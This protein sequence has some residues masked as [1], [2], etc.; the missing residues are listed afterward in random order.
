M[1][2]D[3]RGFSYRIKWMS[4]I[5][6]HGLFLHGVRNNL[7]KIGLDFMPYYGVKAEG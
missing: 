6:K 1:E 2:G 4:N 5:I 7:A 3:K